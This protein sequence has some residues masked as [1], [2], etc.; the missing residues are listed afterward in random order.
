[1]HVLQIKIKNCCRK[2]CTLSLLNQRHHCLL[3][4]GSVQYVVSW[5]WRV[6][7]HYDQLH[8]VT[9]ASPRFRL[10]LLTQ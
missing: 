8:S 4:P 10:L 2:A 7:R 9:V 3:P 6:V 1:M 5:P